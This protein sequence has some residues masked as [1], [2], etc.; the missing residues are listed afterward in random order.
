MTGN[1]PMQTTPPLNSKVVIDQTASSALLALAYKEGLLTET[2]DADCCLSRLAGGSYP[3]WVTVQ[4]LEQVVLFEQLHLTRWL[5]WKGVHGELLDSSQFVTVESPVK[6]RGEVQEIDS[7]ILNSILKARGISPT[8]FEDPSIMK[9]TEAALREL[10]EWEKR[11]AEVPPTRFR[12][13]IERIF[14]NKSKTPPAPRY[15]ALENIYS[16]LEQFNPIASALED[17]LDLVTTAQDRFAHV[18]TPITDSSSDDLF[19]P[20]ST[21]SEVNTPTLLLKLTSAN[22]GVIPFGQSLKQT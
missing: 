17:Y 16:K 8:P 15:V 1:N 12:M 22:L 10:D 20:P 9:K 19:H 5:P 7:A 13:G 18:M 2:Q 11:H 3:K 21:S 14:H 4:A 6:F